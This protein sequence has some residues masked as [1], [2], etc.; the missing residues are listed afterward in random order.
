MTIEA[1][2]EQVAQQDIRFVQFWFTDLLGNLKSIEIPSSGLATALE[3]G[4]GFDGSSIHGFARI[5]ES[6]ML[7]VPDQS[8]FA[9]LPWDNVGRLICDIQLPGGQPYEGD[10]RFVLR[11]AL[12]R[13][14]AQDL[15]MMVGTELEYFYF[16]SPRKPEGVDVAGYF[17]LSPP[18]SA[19]EI[20][21]QAVTAIEK[22]GI[23]VEAA[24][25]E[26]APSQQE[27]DLSHDVALRTADDLLTCRYAI[28]EVARRNG[29]HASFMP[30]PLS[31]E[32][33]SGMHVHQSLFTSSGRNAFFDS[34]DSLHLSALAR[35]YLAGL[36]YYAPEIIG[37][38]AQW[39]NSFKRLVPGFEAPVYVTWASRNRSNMIR[40]PMYQAGKEG[41]TRIEFRAPDSACNPY[42][43]FAVM[44]HAGLDG[45]EKSIPLPQPMERDVFKMSPEE[46]AAAG[47]EMLPGSLNEAITAMEDSRLV[48]SALGDHIFDKFIENKRIK[49]GSYRAHVHEY[50]L[51]RYLPVL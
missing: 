40:I 11:R 17:D 28:K 8:T 32:N 22:I 48:R 18:D 5:D 25:H 31:N 4:I 2:L 1:I 12:K 51:E 13:A 47:I 27:I 3:Q 49:W 35:G 26:V 46:R 34:Q 21:R 36:L 39:V 16:S 33:G 7:A 42:L 38:C 19:S 9:V 20:R 14:A 23:S 37:I 50:E 15:A 41:A 30:K 24:H 29:I 6:D 45:I 10:P 43:A 44:L